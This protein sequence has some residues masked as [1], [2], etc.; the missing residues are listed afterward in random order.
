MK[1]LIL[2]ED[3][4]LGGAESMAVELANGLTALGGIK[5]FFV[6]SDGELRE[7]FI[8][9]VDYF[10]ISS[11]SVF[12]I[13]TLIRE[14]SRIIDQT[15]PD[16]IHAQ[17]ASVG[18][19]A[20]L[21]ARRIN[22]NIKIIMTHH[23][24]R[25]SRMPAPIAFFLFKKYCDFFVAISQ[26]KLQSLLSGGLPEEKVVLIP[27]FI[28]CQKFRESAGS[29]T[30]KDVCHELGIGYESRVVCMT[31]RLIPS[32]RFDKFL[33]ILNDCAGKT[34]ENIVGLI[35]GDGPERGRLES[36]ADSLMRKN[37]QVI[38]LGY[39]KNVARY[40]SASDVFLF[41]SQ[42]EVLPMSLIEAAVLGVPIVCSNIPGNNDVVEQGVNGFLVDQ[43]QDYTDVVLR[44]ING[45]ESIRDMGLHGKKRAEQ[46]FDQKVVINKIVDVYRRV[47][48]G[49]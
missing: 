48:G 19:L 14:L 15:S 31:G 16:I 33:E 11:F 43:D 46:L 12:N 20:G 23:S 17:G 1:V 41:S 25:F 6:A 7:R 18:I 32:K 21:S 27:N 35:V 49:V 36:L 37:L 9:G 42:R 28:D 47:L 40:L 5:V 29:D 22:K 44:F 10:S 30:R 3:L 4:K 8:D 45:D 34:K 26:S 39:Q 24:R 2:N 13:P 38:F